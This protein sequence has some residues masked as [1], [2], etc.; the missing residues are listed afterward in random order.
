MSNYFFA[1]KLSVRPAGWP[2]GR[3]CGAIEN[4]IFCSFELSKMLVTLNGPPRGNYFVLNKLFENDTF[5]LSDKPKCLS[6]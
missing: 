5:C 2:R 4:D 1:N 3:P 6:V